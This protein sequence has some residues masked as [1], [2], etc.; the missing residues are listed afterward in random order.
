MQPATLRAALALRAANERHA[1]AQI[2]R[3]I[4]A[5]LAKLIASLPP[6]ELDK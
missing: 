3:A 6:K 5:D 2:Q 1:L 4:A